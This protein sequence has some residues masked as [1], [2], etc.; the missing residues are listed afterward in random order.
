MYRWI[1]LQIRHINSPSK[2]WTSFSYPTL[3]LIYTIGECRYLVNTLYDSVSHSP[4]SVTVLQLHTVL[5]CCNSTQCYSVATPHSPTVLQLHAAL[6]HCHSKILTIDLASSLSGLS[7]FSL[8]MTLKTNLKHLRDSRSSP[9]STAVSYDI[10]SVH[11]CVASQSLKNLSL[12]LILLT[13]TC[14]YFSTGNRSF[15]S[16]TGL[17]TVLFCSESSM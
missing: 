14:P 9:R 11:H 1:S 13:G 8:V 10:S 7:W 6:Q 17:L 2:C 15:P 5:Q 3:P 12:V 16:V 4:H